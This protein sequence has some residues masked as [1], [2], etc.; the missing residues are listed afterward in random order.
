MKNWFRLFHPR[1]VALITTVDE[2]GRINAAPF[3]WLTPLCDDPPVIAIGA[4]YETHTFENIE[5]TG[6][7]V[8]NLSPFEW[9]EKV[10]IC[11]RRF[12]RGVNELEKAGLSWFPSK[13]VKPPRVKGALFWLECRSI[14]VEKEEDKYGIII[15]E[16]VEMEKGE[17]K[18]ALLHIGGKEYTSAKIPLG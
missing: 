11:A 5:R 8:I 1:I 18:E 2:R 13:R 4:W 16:I 10:E 6:E 7:L 14:K 15:A 3:S 17:D 9:K 12:G